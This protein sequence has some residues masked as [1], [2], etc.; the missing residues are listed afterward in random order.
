M[1]IERIEYTPVGLLDEP[2]QHQYARPRR[3]ADIATRLV[4]HQQS[5]HGGMTDT[6]CT[7]CA[8]LLGKMYASSSTQ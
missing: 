8:E 2:R 1:R 7:A 4:S 3:G 6:S 5:A